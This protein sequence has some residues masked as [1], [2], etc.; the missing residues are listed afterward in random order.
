MKLAVQVVIC[1]EFPHHIHPILYN[2]VVQVG[3][4]RNFDKINNAIENV[5]SVH[6]YPN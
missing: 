3:F 6:K 5:F 2:T 1:A 4:K